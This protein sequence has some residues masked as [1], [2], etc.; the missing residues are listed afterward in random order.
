MGFNEF[1]HIL[2]LFR[3]QCSEGTFFYVGVIG[4]LFDERSYSKTLTLKL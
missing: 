4:Y 3:F 2:Y 1:A